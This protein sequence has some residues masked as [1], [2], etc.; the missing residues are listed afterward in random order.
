VPPARNPFKPRPSPNPLATTHPAGSTSSSLFHPLSHLRSVQSCARGAIATFLMR[1]AGNNCIRVPPAFVLIS[2]QLASWIRNAICRWQVAGGHNESQ[3]PAQSSRQLGN[4]SRER[5]IF[6][7]P[8][9]AL[10]SHTFGP[11]VAELV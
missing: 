2:L 6:M 8:I 3:I 1:L 9:W 7:H 10:A 4:G 11:F 5:E